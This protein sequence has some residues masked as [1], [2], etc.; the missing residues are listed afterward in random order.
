MVDND[1]QLHD[2]IAY[3][4]PYLGYQFNY[5][6]DWYRPTYRDTLL[7]DQPQRH[8]PIASHP[9]PQPRQHQPRRP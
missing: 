1:E 3:L 2:T 9:L 8:N 4:D 6:A 5:P 7:Y